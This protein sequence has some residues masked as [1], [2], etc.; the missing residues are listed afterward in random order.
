MPV[1]WM[2]KMEGSLASDNDVYINVQF[3]S[4]VC[5]EARS[6][7]PIM[8]PDLAV[9]NEELDKFI[10]G[11][12]PVLGIDNIMASG[13]TY[14][15]YSLITEQAITCFEERVG[16]ITHR[17]AL[18]LNMLSERMRDLGFKVYLG[19]Q[20][21]LAHHPRVI[22]QLDSVLKLC[23]RSERGGLLTPS[24]DLLVLDESE[25]LL[26][27]CTSS[28]LGSKQPLMFKA[29]C[30]IIKAAKRVM[31]LDAFM[32]AET[33]AFMACLHRPWRVIRNTRAPSRPRTYVF[34][35]C[36]E[37]WLQRIVAAR[38]AG[39]HVAVASLSALELHRLRSTSSTTLAAL[40]RT[41][42]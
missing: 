35:N 39:E 6:R 37:E 31:L 29:F 41:C 10:S 8:D 14:L 38:S 9:L 34:T 27:H 42:C 7:E 21:D 15:Q 33:R 23:Q 26:A 3:L 40:R 4:R 1:V 25:S 20:G 24:F 2:S 16:F 32:G 18:A 30:A 13:K 36:Q 17:T 28:T 22:C 5:R 11:E 19:D 12:Q